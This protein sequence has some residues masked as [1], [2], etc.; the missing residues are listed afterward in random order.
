MAKAKISG[1]LFDI[2]D[3]LF[4]RRRAQNLALQ[5]PKAEHLTKA[6][7]LPFSNSATRQ[8]QSE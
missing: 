1:I 7:A 3:T 2:D 6:P 5:H 8:M 4:D